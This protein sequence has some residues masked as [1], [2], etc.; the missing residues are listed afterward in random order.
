MI[1]SCQRADSC[2]YSH[3]IDQEE[4][5]WG[6]ARRKKFG[7]YVL[8]T[9]PSPPLKI[10]LPEGQILIHTQYTYRDYIPGQNIYPCPR[11][12]FIRSTFILG[13][14]SEADFP[15]LEEEMLYQ[16]HLQVIKNRG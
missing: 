16:P 3:Q 11:V 13:D 10:P 4:G 9:F 1:G 8:D 14:Y 15:P 12:L 5:G 7:E 6:Q 2:P